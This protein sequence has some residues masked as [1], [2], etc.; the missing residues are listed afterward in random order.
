MVALT[1]EE[2]NARSGHLGVLLSQIHSH[3]T[4]LHKLT[5]ATLANHLL[6]GDA[7]VLTQVFHDV[8]NGQRMVVYLDRAFDDAFGQMHVDIRVIDD[9]IG[10]ER[11]QYTFQVAYRTIGCLG[12]IGDDVGRNLQ[13][14]ATAFR[15]QDIDTQLCV[16]LFEL[17]NKSTREACE[18]TVFHTSKIYW[19]TV[20]GQNNLFA[21]T[22]QVVEDVEER[23]KRLG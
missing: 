7:K 21:K 15:V 16:G 19:R 5:L 3:L 12:N 10:H 2:T 18:Q 13:T 9:A 23:V 4:Y 8:I 11:I 22:E 14:V 17:C 1:N 6:L 20:A